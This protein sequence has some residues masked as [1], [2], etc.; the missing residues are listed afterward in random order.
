VLLGKVPKGISYK[1]RVTSFLLEA[2]IK[3]AKNPI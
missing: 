3:L 2:L 1:V